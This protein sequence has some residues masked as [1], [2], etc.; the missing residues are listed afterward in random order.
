MTKTEAKFGRFKIKN[1][2][3]VLENK[4]Q[5]YVLNE[6]TGRRKKVG[7]PTFK[8]DVPIEELGFVKSLDCFV[9]FVREAMSPQTLL[10]HK[11]YFRQNLKVTV[12]RL[13]ENKFLY[14]IK[15]DDSDKIFS[16]D[17]SAQSVIGGKASGNITSSVD[18]CGIDGKEFTLAKIGKP[19]RISKTTFEKLKKD[20]GYCGLYRDESL[21][22]TLI[23]V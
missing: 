3:V 15:N 4:V 18:L 8:E 6:Y 17:F 19:K 16:R 10:M 21:K 2:K 23:E 11:A 13:N 14:L 7:Q 1:G 5:E 9:V 20:R 12:R 22:Q